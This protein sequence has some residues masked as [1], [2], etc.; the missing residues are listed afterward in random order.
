VYG[1]QE[2]PHAFHSTVKQV[3]EGYGLNLK[4]APGACIYE[5]RYR[6]TL[7]SVPTVM[8]PELESLCTKD[9][10][11]KYHRVIG[12]VMYLQFMTQPDLA[13]VCLFLFQFLEAL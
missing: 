1:L 8:T 9:E 13:Q 11:A 6:P 4:Q 5:G 12:A 7:L 2:A 10:H 3:L